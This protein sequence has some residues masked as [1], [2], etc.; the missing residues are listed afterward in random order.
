MIIPKI[1]FFSFL[2][3]AS[4]S[5][6]SLV[7][8]NDF[9]DVTP[10]GQEKLDQILSTP[11][12]VESALYGAY[13]Q[14]RNTNL[15]GAN[16]S[17]KVV[18]IL[19]QHFTVYGGNNNHIAALEKYDYNYS[20]VEQD[21]EN[22]WTKMYGNISNVNAILGSAILNDASS[23]P[24]NIYKGEALGL[25]AFMHFDLLRLFCEQYTLN[26]NASGIPYATN[27]GLQ[28]PDFSSVAKC[29]EYI[30]DDLLTAETLLQD[31]DKYTDAT[32]FM[33]DRSI[34]FNLHA[35]R[36]TLARVYLTMGQKDKALIYAEKVISESG[37]KLTGQISL[38][39]DV[40]GILSANETLFGVYYKEFY[41]VV[42]PNLQQHISW[43]SLEPRRDCLE[44]FQKEGQD[45]RQNAYF[46]EDLS[47]SVPTFIKLTNVYDLNGQTTPA[48]IIPGINLIRLPEMYYIAAECL[49]ESNPGKATEYFDELITHRGLTKLSERPE[50]QAISQQIINDDRYKEL[51]GEGQ[52]FYNMKRQD[53]SIS[54]PDGNSVKPV[55]IIPIPDIEFDYRN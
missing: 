1:K 53:L 23:F 21:F 14:L 46:K 15:Y 17:F 32:N 38:A 12:G 31:E 34:H 51:W 11:E 6:T 16:L 52:N 13:A 18:D 45:L 42:S 27:F 35:V 43:S 55:Y 9:L 26:P 25:R 47:Y 41:S 10:D 48:G 19:A 4:I 8:C 20:D 3:A 28:T 44:I 39:G 49:L 7:S 24:Y 30:L 2:A 5:C 54:L 36:A 40:A 33:R 29:Y 22:I 50:P 37:R